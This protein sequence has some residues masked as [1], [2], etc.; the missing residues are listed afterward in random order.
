ML[1]KNKRY[2][3]YDIASLLKIFLQTLEK[4]LLE[5]PMF[6]TKMTDDSRSTERKGRIMQKL[7]K[8][9]PEPSQ[10]VFDYLLTH[11]VKI[12]KNNNNKISPHAICR[13]LAITFLHNSSDQREVSPKDLE[14]YFLVM[15]FLIRNKLNLKMTMTGS[16]H[17]YR[18]TPSFFMTNG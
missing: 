4:P 15:E 18:S 7:L 12:C 1:I 14:I 10:S 6:C 11:M 16:V 8:T 9:L 2:G 3:V 5:N 17:S 13:T